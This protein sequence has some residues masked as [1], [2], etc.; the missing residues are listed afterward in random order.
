MLQA[1]RDSAALAV[2]Q[3]AIAIASRFNGPLG[4]GNGG[5]TAGLLS[6]FVPGPVEVTLRRP[7]PLDQ[8]LAL[9]EK[10]SHVAVWHDY[11]L[12]ASARPSHVD[13]AVPAAVTFVEAVQA[14]RTSRLR[15]EHP[16]P[17]CFVCGTHRNDGLDIIPGALPGRERIVATPWVPRAEFAENG[18]IAPEFVF[19]AL[20]CPSGIAAGYHDPRPMVLGRITAEV[21]D[22]VVPEEPYVA[23]GWREGV[24]G[25]KH[26]AGSALFTAQ[27]ELVARAIT[28]WFDI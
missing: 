5:V 18:D 24:E 27:G 4:M 23:I 25:R 17:T 7:V 13:V 2:P 6:R 26:F 28:T 9:D 22:R 19:G 21:L 12:I 16:F 14:S 1:I 8:P 20:D 15:Q 3:P 10:P 11:A